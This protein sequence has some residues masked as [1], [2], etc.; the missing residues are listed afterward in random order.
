MGFGSKFA[1]VGEFENPSP[2][3]GCGNP[4]LGLPFS[5]KEIISQNME[6]V[7]TDGSSVGIPP[8]SRKRKILE[9]VL[10]NCSEEKNPWYSVP[11]YFSEEKT[12]GI[13]FRT[14]SQKRK[15]LGVQF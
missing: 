7:R 1:K 11:N 5:D 8:V 12:L 15:T 10:N 2:F 6:Q 4:T 13:P 9:S 14:I 3:P